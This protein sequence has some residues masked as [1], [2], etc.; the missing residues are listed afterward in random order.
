MC[1]VHSLWHRAV[2]PNGMCASKCTQLL[3]RQPESRNGLHG[4]TSSSTSSSCQR[5]K[6][7]RGPLH[8]GAISD[9][10]VLSAILIKTVNFERDGGI[11]VS[12]LSCTCCPAYPCL[13]EVL[14]LCLGKWTR[15]LLHC[16]LPLKT[17]CGHWN[18]PIRRHRVC[19]TLTS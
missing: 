15:C 14:R 12:S 19:L 5:D 17:G 2:L 13:H 9:V 10:P 11:Q 7:L 6:C 1:V 4:E 18:D 3:Q 8:T 16:A